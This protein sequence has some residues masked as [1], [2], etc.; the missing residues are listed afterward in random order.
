MARGIPLLRAIYEV[1][2]DEPFDLVI[3]TPGGWPKD[4]NLY[5]AQKAFAHA[6]MI[7]RPGATV[8]LVAEC[9]EGTGSAG[10]ER[11]MAEHGFQ[12][13][14]A[15]LEAYAAEGYRIG[16]HK[17][18]QIARD[19]TRVNLV[20]VSAM[21]QELSERLLLNPAPSLDEAVRRALAALSERVRIAVMP[22]ANATIPV[23]T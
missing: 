14:A 19:A 3:V 13:H 8:I 16:P 11:W 10:Y 1:R 2:V 12:S 20:F 15:V 18:W 6:T 23:L 7:A 21:P 22:F 4:I 17:A 9:P 5:Q